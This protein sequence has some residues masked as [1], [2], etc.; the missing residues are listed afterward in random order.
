MAGVFEG[1]G[2]ITAIAIA[3]FALART[4]RLGEHARPVL[5]RL[6]FWIATPAL[7][8]TMLQDAD[9]GVLFS[10]QF[11]VTAA[12][13]ITMGLL[14]GAVAAFRGWGIGPGTVGAMCASYVNSGNLGIPIALYVLGDPTFVA[15]VMLLQQLVM[16]PILMVLLDIGSGK[17]GEGGNWRYLLRPFT[18][19]I[20]VSA[21]AGIAVGALGIEVPGFIMRP[22]ELIGGM[23][24][25]AVLLA[26]GMSLADGKAPLRGPERWQVL[27]ATACK[28]ILHPLIAWALASFAF[29]LEGQALLAVVVTAALPAA[30][31]VFTYASHYGVAERLAR[32]AILLTTL[33]SFPAVLI[34]TILVHP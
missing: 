20:A 8:F 33:L 5:T 19:P 13:M 29:R 1:F 11:L 3:G 2:V 14:Y 21:L 27:L 31:N 10:Q 23:S 16:N 7:L 32:E 17:R 9:T 26:F 4:G 6:A 22:A 24:V 34:V 15:P 25:P 12:A 30:Q 18:N 28:V